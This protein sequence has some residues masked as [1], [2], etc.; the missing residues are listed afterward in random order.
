MKFHFIKSDGTLICEVRQTV[1]FWLWKKYV[2]TTFTRPLAR[3]S[4]VGAWIHW[5]DHNGR[6]PEVL[7]AIEIENEWQ[8]LKF[9]RAKYGEAIA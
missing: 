5:R 9:R 4:E 3:R 8:A 7:F 2:V 1:G 6:G